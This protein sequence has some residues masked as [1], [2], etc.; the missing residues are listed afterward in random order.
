MLKTRN[1]IHA[2]KIPDQCRPQTAT[3]TYNAN[4]P[5]DIISLRLRFIPQEDA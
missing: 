3:A 4:A 2:T 5:T 1:S